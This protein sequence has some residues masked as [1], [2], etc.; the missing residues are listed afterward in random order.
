M[1]FGWVS[2]QKAI[3]ENIRL[4]RAGNNSW[5]LSI[6]CPEAPALLGEAM[7]VRA[8]DDTLTFFIGREPE[9]ELENDYGAITWSLSGS[10]RG[11]PV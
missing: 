9:D 5:F 11:E 8:E 10:T 6:E 1:K 7:D 2:F 3:A 4:N